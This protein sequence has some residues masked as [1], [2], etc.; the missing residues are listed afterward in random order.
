MALIWF[1]PGAA[2]LT[3]GD[4]LD[5]NEHVGAVLQ[6]A[7]PDAL[8]DPPLAEDLHG[9]DPAAARLRMVRR[10]RALFGDHAIDAEAVQQQRHGKADRP[11]ADDEDRRAVRIK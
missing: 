8:L 3:A 1:R 10:R 7:V 9:A 2:D 5:E 4:A 6:A 11:A